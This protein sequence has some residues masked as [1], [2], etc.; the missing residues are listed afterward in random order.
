MCVCALQGVGVQQTGVHT[1][2][3]DGLSPD[4]EDEADQPPKQ[5]RTTRLASRRAWVVRL[6]SAIL[7]PTDTTPQYSVPQYLAACPPPS[8]S[9]PFP[10]PPLSKGREVASPPRSCPVSCTVTQCSLRS[11]RYPNCPPSKPSFPL[12]RC[13]RFS[14][15]RRHPRPTMPTR[16]GK[17]GTRSPRRCRASTAASASGQ[18]LP[19]T[20][21]TKG[22]APSVPLCRILTYIGL[23]Y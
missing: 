8:Y 10:F 18:C 16:M 9:S 6:D 23:S 17:L 3:T 13:C 21:G 7:S 15:S 14:R 1:A 5:S 2:Q 19:K 20:K 12:A 4:D 11:L 22:I